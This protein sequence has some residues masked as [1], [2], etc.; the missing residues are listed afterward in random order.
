MEEKRNE[1][2]KRSPDTPEPGPD[3][4]GVIV[5]NSYTVILKDGA[6]KTAWEHAAWASKIHEENP[7][8][9]DGVRQVMDWPDVD[10]SG[11]FGDFSVK[12]IDKI[13]KDKDV[14]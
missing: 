8:G 4:T 5:P 2:T 1:I 7:D 11:Y 6:K 10:I 3:M 12:T 9:L 14:C 13:R